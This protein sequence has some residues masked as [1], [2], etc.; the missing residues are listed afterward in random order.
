KLREVL[1][2]A[3]RVTVL[4]GGRVVGE[5]PAAGATEQEL[6]TLM[7]GR[8]VA[9]Y[10]RIAIRPYDTSGDRAREAADAAA[11]GLVET[12]PPEH[13]RPAAAGRVALD[14]RDVTNLPPR[15]LIDAGLGHIPEDRQKHGL[16]LPYP[17]RDNLVLSTYDRW[18]FARGI[19]LQL[20]AV[21]DL[22]RRL[23]RTFD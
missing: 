7:V 21:C 18:P 16:V 20:G 10:G 23:I 5:L 2:I 17:I 6:A 11:L 3:D 15:R 14:G 22:A 4:R 13:D 19:L 1:A 8:S 9:L 12:P